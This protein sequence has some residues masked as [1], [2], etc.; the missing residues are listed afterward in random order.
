MLVLVSQVARHRFTRFL[1]LGGSAAIVNMLLMYV[2]VNVCN[3]E[4]PIGRNLANAIALEVSLI[5]S[6]FVY[7]TF[8]WGD[9]ADEFKAG[10]LNQLV[11]YHG[12]AGVVNLVRFLVIFPSL[13]WIGV[14]HLVNTLFG[15]AIGCLVNYFISTKFVFASTDR[16][17]G[18]D[19]CDELF[20][21]PICQGIGIE[22]P[23]EQLA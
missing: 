21:V 20:V 6:F 10:A 18:K 17:V 9:H 12:V 23:L 22:T 8:V 15:I 7:R 4:T 14:H 2:L 11:R 19:A 1:M 16:A 13:D 5:Y 3:W